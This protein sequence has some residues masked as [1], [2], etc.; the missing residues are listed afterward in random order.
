MDFETVF[1]LAAMHENAA[2][3]DSWGRRTCT[4]LDIFYHRYGQFHNRANG[5]RHRY[6]SSLI[7]YSRSG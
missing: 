2:L 4:K 7:H 3:V 6:A 1:T 5:C